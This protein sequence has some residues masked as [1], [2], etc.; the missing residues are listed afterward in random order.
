MRSWNPAGKGSW[1]ECQP[2][3]FSSD[4]RFRPIW[5]LS[6][7]PLLGEFPG[8]QAHLKRQQDAL[9]SRHCPQNFELHSLRRR[10]GVGVGH[11]GMLARGSR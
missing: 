9:L 1:K 11:A 7:D 8:E 5:M 4:A 6:P 10:A 3:Q 2:Q